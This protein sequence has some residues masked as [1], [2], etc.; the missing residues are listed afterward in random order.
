MCSSDLYWG[1]KTDTADSSSLYAPFTAPQSYDICGYKPGQLR[2]AYG[3]GRSV[4]HGNNGHGVTVAIVDAYDSPT[5]LADAQHYAHLNDPAHPLRSSQFTNVQP[6]DPA[7]EAT[8]GGSGWYAEQSLDVESVHAMAPGA[9]IEFVGA[10]DCFDN[11]LLAGVDTAV[12]TANV[13][14]DSW[15]DTLGDIFEGVDGITAFD[16]EFQMAAGTGVS[17]LFSS[18]DDGDNFADFGID[19]PDYPATDPLDRKSVV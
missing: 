13:V 18:G 3:L 9:H 16:N 5:L 14:T 11:N 7:N 17:V 6:T 1:Q 15:G 8:C 4:R 12:S 10:N 19:A 2:S